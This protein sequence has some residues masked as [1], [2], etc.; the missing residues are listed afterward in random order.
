MIVKY[1]LDFFIWNLIFFDEFDIEWFDIQFRNPH[2][3]HTLYFSTLTKPY[4]FCIKLK[5]QIFHN[6][7][8]MSGVQATWII[9]YT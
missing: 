6:L 8:I 3:I 4:N 7:K 1:L 5:I 9:L 2:K